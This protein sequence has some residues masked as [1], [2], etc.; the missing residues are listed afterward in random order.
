MTVA[1][2]WNL[3]HVIGSN[4]AVAQLLVNWLH[5]LCLLLPQYAEQMIRLSHLY[6]SDLMFAHVRAE[7]RRRGVGG[8]GSDYAYYKLYAAKLCRCHTVS[9]SGV[10][11]KSS[12]QSLEGT[13]SNAVQQCC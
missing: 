7:P 12:S 6:E 5:P 2:H 9:W 3:Q 11:H 10:R 8:G 13:L 4:R 1:K